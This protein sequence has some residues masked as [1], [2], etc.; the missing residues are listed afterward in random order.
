MSPLALCRMRVN[1]VRLIVAF[2]LMSFGLMSFG[3]MSHS[4]ICRSVRLNVVLVNVV[5]HTVGVSK[6]LATVSLTVFKLNNSQVNLIV[7][8]LKYFVV[9]WQFM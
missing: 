5:R 6:T 4:A 2:G 8:D 7:S 3:L 1:V 9:V